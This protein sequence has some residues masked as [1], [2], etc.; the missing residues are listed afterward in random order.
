MN[1]SLKIKNIK[2][3][4][5]GTYDIPKNLLEYEKGDHAVHEVVV[6][7]LAHQRAGT[8][9][10]L[11]KSNVAGSGKKPW[12]QKGLGRARAGYR[13]SPIWRGGAV[14]HGPHP[15]SYKKKVSKKVSRLAFRRAF[16]AKVEQDEI[17]VIEEINLTTPKTKDLLT[18]I[19]G[20]DIKNSCLIIL[21]EVSE[22]IRLAS[23][24]LKNIDVMNASHLNTYKVLRYQNLVITNAAMSL[25]QN[26]LGKQGGEE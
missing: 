20:L 7:Y 15:R 23:R 9:S 11:S 1:S 14:A 12:K 24:N 26:R 16:S 4:D 19:N 5:I 10:T 13:Q 17:I 25:I 3:K 6:A 18:I 22:N 8:A 21:D 2:G